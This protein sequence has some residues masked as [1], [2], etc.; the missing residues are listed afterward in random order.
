MRM[1]VGVLMKCASMYYRYMTMLQ[2]W[3]IEPGKRPTFTSVVEQ[4]S[5]NLESMANYMD[6]EGN[7][8]KPSSSDNWTSKECT[9]VEKQNLDHQQENAAVTNS[10]ESEVK[11]TVEESETDGNIDES[12][13]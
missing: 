2:C 3:E 10:S 12:S 7:S 13:L 11:V 1:I 8:A 4:L 6:L 9:D 5:S